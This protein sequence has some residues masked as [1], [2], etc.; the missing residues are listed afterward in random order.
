MHE[1]RNKFSRFWHELKRRKT[2][3]VI[4]AYAAAA[5]GI[6]QLGQILSEEFEFP[7]W[8]MTMLIIILAV[9]FPVAAIFSWVFDITPMG[10]EKTR[11]SADK[12]KQRSDIEIRKWKNTTLISF[13]VIVVLLLYNIVN[14]TLV[15]NKGNNDK[16]IT[17]QPFDCLSN[18]SDLNLKGAIYTEYI[19]GTLTSIEDITLR[20]WP[21]YLNFKENK[22]SYPDLGRE[23]NVAFILKGTLSKLTDN[24]ILIVQLIRTKTESI[25]WAQNYVLDP[26]NSNFFEIQRDITLNV[27]S[28]L[29]AG[30]SRRE[31]FRINKKPSF[32][33]SA[34]KSFI[35]GN[36][37]S[38]RV[39]FNTS[40]GNRFFTKMID[41][42][43]FADAVSSFD[44]AIEQ[45][46]AFALAYA[47]RAI[48]RS[49][50]YHTRHIDRSAIQECKSDIEKA[51]ELDPDLVENLIAQGF[52]FYYCINDY[53]RALGYFTR[54]NKEEPNNWQCIYYMALVQRVLGNWEKSQELMAKVLD[55]NP[56]DPLLLTNIGIS[57]E[58]MRNYDKALYYHDRAIE[59]MP[60]WSSAYKNKV[61]TILLKNGSS[62]EARSIIDTASKRTNDNL[63]EFRIMIDMYEG[64]LQEALHEIELSEPA[65][66]E[67]RGRQLLL[68]AEIYRYMNNLQAYE[69]FS[70]S[71]LSY[72]EKK[73]NDE[74]EKCENYSMLGISYA[75]MN[76]KVKALE[77]GENAVSMSRDNYLWYT[78]RRRDL[79]IIYVL[80]GEYE[81][82]LK[83]LEFLL[84]KPSL[85]SVK[86]LQIDPVWNPV[87]GTSGFKTL[88]EKYSVKNF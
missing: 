54:A 87:R 53:G 77:Y 45:D 84:G 74:P 61:T 41:D 36:A 33:P 71:A 60:R 65:D 26:E 21:P 32:N 68:Y 63:K 31:K 20:A 66:F 52:Y 50:G 14:A 17:I 51:I 9:G 11:P 47:K 64:R 27:T 28:S 1:K 42:N 7:G 72:Y 25:A 18:E 58:M 56:Q 86:L 13:V 16:S 55:F 69:T 35:Q 49:W 75:G 15:D 6:L 78:D 29:N 23:L 4:V 38:Q 48:I 79:A 59:I 88:I 44:K 22:K 85:V 43:L 62:E 39:I 3:R 70:Q 76:N 46:P 73:V 2:D 81:K 83:E 24:I 67:D 8:V 10:I 37:V 12:K 34:M 80:T 19:N 30:L 5:F 82:C 40:S 57:E